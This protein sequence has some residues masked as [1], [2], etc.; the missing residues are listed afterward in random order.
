MEPIDS[1]RMLSWTS[2]GCWAL[3]PGPCLATPLGLTTFLS[4]WFTTVDDGIV[5]VPFMLLTHPPVSTVLRL[6]CGQ[7]FLQRDLDSL[8]IL[9]RLSFSMI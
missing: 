5:I 4:F 6:N 3:K 2:R 8:P 1:A 7:I 9:D